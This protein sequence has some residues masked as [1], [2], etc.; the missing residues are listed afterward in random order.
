MR[1]GKDDVCPSTIWRSYWHSKRKT[2]S[3]DDPDGR[4]SYLVGGGAPGR[5]RTFNL[6][7]KSP[8]LCLVE[9]RVRSLVR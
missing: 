8:L 2:P 5:N 4:C 9:L 7:I 3:I 1:C 6:G